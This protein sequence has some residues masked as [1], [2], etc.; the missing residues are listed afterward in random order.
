M[1]RSDVCL[2]SYLCHSSC[3]GPAVHLTFSTHCRWDHTQCF[4]C[5]G[6]V[7]ESGHFGGAGLVG[8]EDGRC[9]HW[10]GQHTSSAAHQQYPRPTRW[11]TL[12][13][14]ERKNIQMCRE[15][16]VHKST[17]SGFDCCHRISYPRCQLSSVVSPGAT[18]VYLS[19]MLGAAHECF[20]GERISLTSMSSQMNLGNFQLSKLRTE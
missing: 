7:G 11:R 14:A 4:K 5:P 10:K 8:S 20:Q 17:A 6:I 3:C 9:S 19:V 16:T 1:N 15:A 13:C 12:V 2:M 18:I